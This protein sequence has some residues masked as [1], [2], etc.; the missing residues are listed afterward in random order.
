MGFKFRI[1]CVEDG[2]RVGI[3]YDLLDK[4]VISISVGNDDG[5]RSQEGCF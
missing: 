4:K 3:R 2:A 1:C 5:L